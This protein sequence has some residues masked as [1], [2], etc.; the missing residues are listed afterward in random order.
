MSILDQIVIQ[1]HKEINFRK[2]RMKLTFLEKGLDQPIHDFKA[3]L[4]GETI[5]IIA[6]IKRMSPSAGLIRQKFDPVAI[7]HIYKK[8]GAQAIS[9]LTDYLFF[10]GS[11][12]YLPMIKQEVAIPVLRKEFIIDEYQITESR[13]LGADCILL[14]ATLLE[15]NTL[16]HFIECASQLGLASLVE[17]HTE[18][19]LDR[20]LS[21]PV[22]IVGINNRN[23]DT[24]SVD[25]STSMRLKSKIPS[26][27]ITV[28]ESGIQSREDLEK[29]NNIGFNG[30]LIGESLMKAENIGETLE[31]LRLKG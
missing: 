20:V 28:S 6:E 1:K 3:A 19:E 13:Y 22:E 26:E 30:V 9:F 21:L 24:L 12:S 7:A 29:L 10:G 17:V 23:L 2:G 11:D 14:I 16:K 18:E 25:L 15:N 4:Q 8:H 5:S 31:H 27:I